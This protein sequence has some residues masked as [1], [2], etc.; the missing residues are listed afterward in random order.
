MTKKRTVPFLRTAAFLTVLGLSGSGCSLV[1]IATGPKWSERAAPI[2]V[3]SA[4]SDHRGKDRLV[5]LVFGD[6]GTGE[7]D[8]QRVADR[9]AAECRAREGCDFALMAGDNIYESGVRP[10][11]DRGEPDPRF[12][13]QFEV[14]YRELGRMDFWAVAGNHDWY[15]RRSVEA[16]VAYTNESLRWRMLSH[17]YA[18]PMLPAWIRIYALDTT[19]IVKRRESG[20]I[21]RAKQELCGG[22]GWKLLLGHHPIYSSGTHASRGGELPRVKAGLLGPLIESCGVHLYFAGHDHHQ[23]HLTAASFDQI[24][25]GA[26]G[27]LRRLR[28]VRDRSPD[29]RQLAVES[30]F[31]FAVIEVTRERLELRFFGYPGQGGSEELHCRILEL[32]TFDDPGRRSRPCD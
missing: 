7:A 15:R 14:P 30:K 8:Q 11:N 10:A 31:G 12:S 26:A 5:F 17:D 6:A 16:Q 27:K 9:M 18:I 3:T 23:E 21:D 20:Q 22:G 29:V 13:T 25:Q 2:A 24:V 1:K 28:E 19:K 32:A 4:I